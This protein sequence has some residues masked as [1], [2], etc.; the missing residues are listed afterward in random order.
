MPKARQFRKMILSACP[1]DPKD[2][3]ALAARAA[4]AGVTHLVV[5]GM[6]DKSRYELDDPADPYLH[7]AIHNSTLFK[8]ARPES[9]ADWIPAEFAE[10]NMQLLRERQAVLERHGL[11]GMFSGVEP[12]YLPESVYDKHPNWRG[13]RVDQARRSRHPRFAPC[14]DHPEVLDLYRQAAAEIVNAGP[15]IDTF[16][17][18]TNDSGAGIC[19]SDGLYPEPNGP[20][21]CRDRHYGK[22]VAGW[23]E[24]IIQGAR[25]AGTTAEAFISTHA[26]SDAQVAALLSVAE[27]AVGIVPRRAADVLAT[28]PHTR[29]WNAGAS[30]G[31]PVIGI[32]NPLALV[33]SIRSAK[34][35][36]ADRLAVGFEMDVR[37]GRSGDDIMFKVFERALSRRLASS[38]ARMQ[39]LREIAVEE[40]G[41]RLANS[42][43][44]AWLH[45]YR[46][47]SSLL[48]LNAGG[49]L[50][51]IAIPAQRWLTRPLVAFPLELPPE[52]KDYY[53]RFQFQANT[54]EQAADMLDLQANRIVDGLKHAR[55]TAQLMERAGASIKQAEAAFASLRDSVDDGRAKESFDHLV[56]RLKAVQSLVRT[57]ANVPQF[58][59][60]MDRRKSDMLPEMESPEWMPG[61]WERTW[62]YNIVR[63]ELDNVTE[64][65]DLMR[66][67]P[68]PLIR[69]ASDKAEEDPFTFGP[70]LIEQLEKKRR[71]MLRHWL[72]FDRLYARPNR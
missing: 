49:T 48:L 68:V 35:A 50:M 55:A 13:P 57:C 25:D 21:A 72:D 26:M 31:S 61:S 47:L 64:L 38:F 71:I 54:E 45:I 7:W 8:F 36:H 6:P 19:W 33:E 17:F 56:S 42:L 70:D 67:S 10:A 11:H 34:A 20:S 60:Y 43:L 15:A 66:A 30:N 18:G 51:Q 9:L 65:I 40:V 28:M 41:N 46:G 2:T 27:P 59:A 63:D 22:R 4:R 3:D 29:L 69:M 53:R 16:R 5:S 14:I 52:E 62:M 32:P 44:D 37:C 1:D 24:A 23:L 39:F 12:M 58:Q